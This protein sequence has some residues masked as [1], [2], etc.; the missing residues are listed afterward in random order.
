[1][2]ARK[3]AEPLGFNRGIRN[4]YAACRF[5]ELSRGSVLCLLNA[6]FGKRFSQCHNSIFYAEIDDHGVRSGDTGRI[7]AQWWHPV[8]SDE[9]LDVLHRVM[10][11]ALYCL[12]RMAIE[13]ARKVGAFFLSSIFCHA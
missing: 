9:A 1:M 5:D 7:L 4:F 3:I 12:V 6:S 8:A 13:M 10:H 11:S 2:I